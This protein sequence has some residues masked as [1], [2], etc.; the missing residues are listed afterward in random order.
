[1]HL[2]HPGQGI[3]SHPNLMV[4]LVG[5]PLLSLKKQVEGRRESSFCPTPHLEELFPIATFPP[6]TGLRQ[7]FSHTLSQLQVLFL[8]NS[9]AYSRLL[10]LRMR[11]PTLRHECAFIA[12]LSNK[13]CS[14]LHKMPVSACISTSVGGKE[15]RFKN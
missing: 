1:M 5:V 12:S 4:Y 11:Q 8:G 6:Q 9:L 10:F 14:Y 2:L 15:P 13:L 7:T 3:Y